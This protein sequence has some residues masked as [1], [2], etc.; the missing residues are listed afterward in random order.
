[1]PQFHFT[2]GGP[3]PDDQLYADVE[4]CNSLSLAAFG[5][6]VDLLF[7]FLAQ[8]NTDLSSLLD[9]FSEKHSV[10]PPEL[11]SFVRGLFFVCFLL[12]NCSFCF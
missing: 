12:F 9:T 5:E 7:D 6:L 4:Q 11:R 8:R 1:M 2:A 10:P 3:P